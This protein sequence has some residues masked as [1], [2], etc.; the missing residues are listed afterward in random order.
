MFIK[1]LIIFALAVLIIGS[2]WY[3]LIYLIEDGKGM[4]FWLNQSRKLG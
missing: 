3:G 2:L 4:T 1:L